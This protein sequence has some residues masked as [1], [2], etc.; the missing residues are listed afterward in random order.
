[1]PEEV[2]AIARPQLE[3][4]VTDA[5]CN[6]ISMDVSLT[7]CGAAKTVEEGKVFA[8]FLEENKGKFDGV[9]ACL[10][11]FSDEA[12]TI[13]ALKDAGVPILIQACPDEIGKMDFKQRRDAF[14]GKLAITDLFYQYNVPFSLTQSHVVG[15]DTEEF[16]N[17]IKKFGAVCRTVKGLKKLTVV[18]VGARTTAFK[19]MRFDE[20]T[21]Q[22]H[23]ITIETLDLSDFFLRMKS[24]D[25]NSSE[26]KDK[27]NYLNNYANFKN[28]PKE[29]FAKMAKAS[30]VADA[31]AKEYETDCMTIRCWDEFQKVM[32]ISVCNLISE[33]NDR[34]IVTACEL[35]L[36]NAIAMKAVSAASGEPAM[37]LDF[38]NNYGDDKN[39]CIL[40]HCGPIASSLMKEKGEIEEH[41]MLKKV[42]GDGL[43]WG[44]NKGHI[45]PMPATYSSTK[46]ED[47]RIVAYVDNG[48]FTDDVI[49]KE[50]FGTGGVIEIEDLQKKLY[51]IAKN[52]YRHHV[53]VSTG[54]NKDA[55][56]EAY[57]NYLGYD[58][59]DLG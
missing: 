34:G 30:M 24:V 39:K 35:D 28:V 57:E 50:F 5:G 41:M 9:I 43:S 15:I 37:C 17:E 7:G 42:L 26:F 29:A 22:R 31:V 49:E 33:L 8:K 19:T 10:A 45:R 16:Q 13:T 56:L 54:N 20:I 2:I 27:I 46:T 59:V 48:R 51:K 6:F 3:K 52:G 38:N 18:A 4:A 36:S 12:A 58:I 23:G 25:E 55:I 11:N 40:F 47:G 1:M 14:C 44:V 32:Q 21:A 53:S